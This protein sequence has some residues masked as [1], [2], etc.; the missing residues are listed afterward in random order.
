MGPRSFESYPP[1]NFLRS[2]LPQGAPTS[3][4]SV[5]LF[6]LLSTSLHLILFCLLNFIESFLQVFLLLF[7]VQ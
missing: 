2:A 1:S 3:P 4:G 7:L 5:S 6:R